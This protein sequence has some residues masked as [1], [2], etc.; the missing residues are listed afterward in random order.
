MKHFAFLESDRL[1]STAMQ[2]QYSVL[3]VVLSVLVASMAAYTAFLLAER[4][5]SSEKNRQRYT[6]LVA[7]ALSLGGGVWSMHFIGML[8][9]SLPVAVRYDV[10]TTI[11]PSCLRYLPA[12]LYSVVSVVS[13]N[14]DSSWYYAAY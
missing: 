12:W 10:L 5:H 6:W 11:V 13:I 9:F 14:L 3:L 1:M 8:A 7:G 2:G 4:I